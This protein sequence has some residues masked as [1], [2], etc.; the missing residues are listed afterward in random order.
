MTDKLTEL[1][2]IFDSIICLAVE[3]P[4]LHTKFEL[5]EA[6]KK[7]AMKGYEMCKRNISDDP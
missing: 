1:R 5:M 7:E 6:I 4:E 2:N 3:G